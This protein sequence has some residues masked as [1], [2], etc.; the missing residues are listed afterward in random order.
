MAVQ[1]A[2]LEDFQVDLMKQ[3]L[4]ITGASKEYSK[5]SRETPIME[6]HRL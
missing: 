1:E 6:W 4:S 3:R 2:Y 5:Y